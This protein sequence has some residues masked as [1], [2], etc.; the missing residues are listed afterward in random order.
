MPAPN[1]A[2]VTALRVDPS[3]VELEAWTGE[4]ASVAF[5]AIATYGDGSEGALDLVS[6]TL[7][8]AS[9]GTISSRGEYVSVD[10]N[11]GDA[12]VTAT[13]LDLSATASLSLRYRENL[14]E[15][16]LDSEVAA[17]FEAA[18]GQEGEGIE[19][20]YPLDGTAVPRNLAGL[21]VAWDGMS[22]GE[23]ARVRF[24]SERTDVSVYTQ[25]SSWEVPTDLWQTI[26]ATNS[27]GSVD[28]QVTVGDWS[29]S[30][31]AD[32][33]ASALVSV[34]VNRLDA[35]GSVTYWSLADERIMRVPAGSTEAAPFFPTDESTECFGCHAISEE[36]Q[37]MV[38]THYGVDGQY[39]ILDVADPA[40]P[41][42]IY[43][44]DGSKRMTMRAIS[45]D[46][47]WMAGVLRGAVQ[48]YDLPTNTLVDLPALDGA[49]YTHPNWSPGG[50]ELVA[51]RVL[52]SARFVDDMN[53]HD[54]EIVKIGWNGTE[55]TDVEVLVEFQPGYNLYYPEFSPD[56]EWVVFNRSTGDS[57][58]D[59]DAELFIVPAGGG[60]PIRLDN[61]NGEGA[62]GNSWARWAPL[63]DDD[64]LWFG[65]SSLRSYPV[66][67]T[68]NP[69]IWVTSIDPEKA[70]KGEDPSTT[71]Y[72]LPGQDPASDNHV[73][74]WWSR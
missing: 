29:G 72:W 63:P 71:P 59:D 34:S 9:I 17:A 1:A 4:P 11:G 64:V 50:D 8:N 39:T 52:D 2:T 28:V 62:L 26:T 35:T 40:N 18:E 31:L 67:G 74:L 6:W 23:V 13:H 12:T 60:T 5:S 69:Q 58:S 44:L 38:V 14:Y 51:V 45:P 56:G 54:G 41:E 36:R 15:G 27:G 70:R 48:L 24:A 37:W 32:V 65:F 25:S 21:V 73:P 16:E 7:S 49:K 33:R 46:G 10:T 42:I 30:S 3:E 61:A 68:S 20:I 43:W 55:L 53:F 66:E 47:N 19:V 57:T 22:E